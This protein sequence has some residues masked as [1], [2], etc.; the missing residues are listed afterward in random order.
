MK[1]TNRIFSLTLIA[2]A[3]AASARTTT[4]QVQIDRAMT[5][6]EETASSGEDA[7]SHFSKTKVKGKTAREMLKNYAEKSGYDMDE[8]KIMLRLKSDELPESDDG[9]SLVGLARNVDV[10]GYAVDVYSNLDPKTLDE[11]QK[12]ALKALFDLTNSGV[13]V[14]VESSG[15]VVCGV[16]FPALI[17]LD[18]ENGI[19]YSLIPTN[20]SC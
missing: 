12:K 14:G 3:F 10:V 2:F 7:T 1:L 16:T 4:E 20:T 17:V 11:A 18:V 8:V 15:W 6:L 19:V 13:L 5:V 9:T